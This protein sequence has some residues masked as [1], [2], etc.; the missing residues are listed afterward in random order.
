MLSSLEE[1]VGRFV[2]LTTYPISVMFSEG[3]V[4]DAGPHMIFGQF[5]VCF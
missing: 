3:K 2:H 1:K 5:E 4:I